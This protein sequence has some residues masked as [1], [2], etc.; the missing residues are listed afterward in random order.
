MAHSTLRNAVILT[1]LIACTA[2]PAAA[3]SVVFDQL[4]WL[5]LAMDR[6]DS[7]WG[8][9]TVDYTGAPSSRY[10]NLNVDDRWVVQNMVLDSP[11]GDGNSQSVSTFFDLGVSHGTDVPS[12]SHVFAIESAPRDAIPLGGLL[13]ATVAD[14][15]FQ[16]GGAGPA[17]LVIPDNLNRDLETGGL[18]P[19]SSHVTLVRG[20][21]LKDLDKFVNQALGVND[22]VRGSVSN[23]LKFLQA[24]KVIP[25]KINADISRVR[26]VLGT[27]PNSGNP[28]TTP[29]SWVKSK[30]DLYKRVNTKGFLGSGGATVTAVINALKRGQDVEL[31]VRVPANQNAGHTINVVG[32]RVKRVNGKR[33]VEIDVFDDNQKKSGADGMKTYTLI[34]P[35]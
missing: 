17:P 12:L 34:S 26:Q 24:R 21:K 27:V 20:A 16:I 29:H 11:F 9:V 1:V 10:F 33:V 2:T 13:A 7:S 23:S 14:L 25:Q 28:P 35:I 30:Q 5:G 22:C 4:N 8:K 15:D 6:P 18:A 19:A 32:L 31:D 3:Q